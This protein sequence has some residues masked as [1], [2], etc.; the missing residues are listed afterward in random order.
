MR[1][2][3]GTDCEPE[4][5]HG[6]YER[7]EETAAPVARDDRRYHAGDWIR[8]PFDRGVSFDLRRSVEALSAPRA[9][10]VVDS[11]G[12]LLVHHAAANIDEMGAG[13]GVPRRQVARGHDVVRVE[14]AAPTDE[15]QVRR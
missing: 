8:H 1:A 2:G 13:A 10:G 14:V 6:R 5:A 9:A 11:V 12:P 3:P 4:T 15:R 7:D